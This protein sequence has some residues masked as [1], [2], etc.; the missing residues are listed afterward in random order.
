[1]IDIEKGTITQG[2]KTESIKKFEVWF[3]CPL[4][5]TPDRTQAISAAVGLEFDPHLTVIPAV[6]VFGDTLQEQYMRSG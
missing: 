4:G 2:D 3:L 5:I 6:V 1:M